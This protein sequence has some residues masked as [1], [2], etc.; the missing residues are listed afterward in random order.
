MEAEERFGKCEVV[1]EARDERES[2]PVLGLT[3]EG[4]NG[5]NSAGLLRSVKRDCFVSE[6]WT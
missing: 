1:V 4:N 6:I 3:S 5:G 2:W